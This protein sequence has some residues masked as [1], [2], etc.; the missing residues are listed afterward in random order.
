MVKVR[1][2]SDAAS[3]RDGMFLRAWIATEEIP[4]TL[5]LPWNVLSFRDGR[6]YVYVVNDE[7]KVERRWL[8]LGMQG[9]RDIQ[10]IS[11][12]KAGDQVMVRGQ[13]LAAEGSRVKV[14][15]SGQ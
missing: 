1:T 7:N 13:H 15:G 14:R 4:H 11:R 12:L 2:T 6:P 5:V 9:L 8:D 10:V 3:L